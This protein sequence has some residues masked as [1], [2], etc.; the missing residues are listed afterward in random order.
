VTSPQGPSLPDRELVVLECLANGMRW[1]Q[2]GAYTGLTRAQLK[3]AQPSL[4]ETLGADT[5]AHAVAI[6]YQAGLLPR[7]AE[8]RR[9]LIDVQRGRLATQL[10]SSSSSPQQQSGK[11]ALR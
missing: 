7:G 4:Y 8:D 3:R 10:V 11:D 5:A 6:A 2:I 9:H 1:R